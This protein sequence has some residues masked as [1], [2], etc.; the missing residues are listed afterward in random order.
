V[1]FSPGILHGLDPAAGLRAFG[2]LSALGLQIAFF[3]V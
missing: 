3:D 1:L 2:K